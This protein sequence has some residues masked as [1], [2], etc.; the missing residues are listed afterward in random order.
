MHMVQS[1]FAKRLAPALPTDAQ[2]AKRFAFAMLISFSLSFADNSVGLGSPSGGGAT[3]L[4]DITFTFTFYPGNSSAANPFCALYVDNNLVEQRRL[5]GSN[6]GAFRAMNL[7]RTMHEWYVS[8]EDAVSPKRTLTILNLGPPNITLISPQNAYSTL[9]GTINFAFTYQ[10]GTDE[11][12]SANCSL[13]IG[14]SLKGSA[15]A[16]SG[17]ITSIRHTLEPG[18]YGWLVS[19]TRI[20]SGKFV[21]S[22]QRVVRVAAQKKK[23]ALNNATSSNASNATKN[24]VEQPI[25]FNFSV[26]ATA[27]G[28]PLPRIVVAESAFQGEEIVLKLLDGNLEPIAGGQITAAMQGGKGSILLNKTDSQGITSFTPNSGGNYTF[29]ATGMALAFEPSAQIIGRPQ[30]PQPETGKNASIPA[31]ANAQGLLDG[32]R[33]Q[34]IILLAGAALA[35]LLA[36]LAA[37]IFTRRPKPPTRP[38]KVVLK[39]IKGG[40]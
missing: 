6:E 35:A 26:D 25:V 24:D 2:L 7:S 19:C 39:E 36:A 15:V 20:E 8:C 21:N 1:Q 32:Q 27:A 4:R 13:G 23:P 9:N 28:I 3:T 30:E 12:P 40:K 22:E 37:F 38:G 29:S 11:L 17:A 18:E 33:S 14:V 5:M 34:L 31:S 10:S 16:I